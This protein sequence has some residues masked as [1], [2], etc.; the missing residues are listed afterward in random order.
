MIYEYLYNSKVLS[1]CREDR[2]N[3]YT[4]GVHNFYVWSNTVES[5]TLV[6]VPVDKRSKFRGIIVVPRLALEPSRH[7]SSKSAG[8]PANNDNN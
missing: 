6:T 4:A 3:V 1:L 2:Y 5:K 8:F 7:S